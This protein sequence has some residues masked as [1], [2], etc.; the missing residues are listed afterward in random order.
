M[1]EN[2]QF[3]LYIAFSLQNKSVVGYG[4][5]IND[6]RLWLRKT[7]IT[8][9]EERLSLRDS[10]DKLLPVFDV[11]YKTNTVT[12]ALVNIEDEPVLAISRIILP[13]DWYKH[14]KNMLVL[15]DL[16]ERGIIDVSFDNTELGNQ[17]LLTTWFDIYGN[18]V[19][20]KLRF[21]AML[22]ELRFTMSTHN[23]DEYHVFYEATR[24]I[25]DH[26]AL[27]TYIPI[28]DIEKALL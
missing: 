25:D 1:T 23:E 19:G 9:P 4:R 5:S 21:N 22:N 17:Q 14:K 8:T 27:L 6:L 13:L 7:I 26:V 12:T 3:P 28:E 10:L 2:K 18:S 16:T 15:S 20:G 24:H 11:N